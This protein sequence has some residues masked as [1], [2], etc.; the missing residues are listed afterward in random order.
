MD[1]L[2]SI[3]SLPII[4][5]KHSQLIKINKKEIL[6]SNNLP[7]G[8]EMLKD[9]EII[10][11]NLLIL[12]VLCFLALYKQKVGVIPLIITAGFTGYLIKNLF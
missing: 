6:N 9:N 10:D 8:I 4:N 7:P 1:R 2:K 11:Y 3:F 12:S 5:K